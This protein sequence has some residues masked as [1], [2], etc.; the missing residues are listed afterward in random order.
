MRASA[1]ELLAKGIPVKPVSMQRIGY[2]SEAVKAY[3]LD[4]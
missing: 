1:G 4:P 3:F 2:G